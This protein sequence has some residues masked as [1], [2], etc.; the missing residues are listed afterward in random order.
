[1][2]YIY[3]VKTTAVRSKTSSKLVYASCVWYFDRAYYSYE[4][5][6]AS[7]RVYS[8]PCMRETKSQTAEFQGWVSRVLRFYM[9]SCRIRTHPAYG[10]D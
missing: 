2:Y 6:V 10:K 7:Y 9:D 5:Y 8:S 4:L 1:M 3:N